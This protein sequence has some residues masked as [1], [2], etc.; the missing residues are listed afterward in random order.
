MKI[1]SHRGNINGPSELEND[2]NQLL[3]AVGLGFDVEVDIWGVDGEVWLG[4]DKPQYL[5]DK[6]F[7]YKIKDVAWFH[8]KNL[9]AIFILQ[10]AI[11]PLNF[12]WHQS[13]SYAVTSY[14]YSWASPGMPLNNLSINVLPEQSGANSPDCFGV[15]TDYPLKFMPS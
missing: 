6:S 12:F 13:D 2:P 1:I 9:E 7:I 5:V 15:C 3:H 4:H 8:C 10:N 14:G 11:Y